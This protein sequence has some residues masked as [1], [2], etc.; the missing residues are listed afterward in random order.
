MTIKHGVDHVT[1]FG[2]TLHIKA[3]NFHKKFGSIFM[4]PADFNL[5]ANLTDFNQNIPNTVFNTPAQPNGCTGMTQADVA[6]DLDH[7][8]YSPYFT[9]QKTCE[10]EDHDTTQPCY[11]DNSLNSTTVYGVQ[12]LGETDDQ[13]ALIH[14]KQWYSVKP[15]GGD[16]FLG[17]V[18]AMSTGRSSVSFAADWYESFESPVDGVV[19]SAGGLSSGHN[20]KFCGLKTIND[21]QYLIA[22]P[23]I[24]PS[25]GDNGFCYFSKEIVNGLNGQAFTLGE[26]TNVAQ[27]RYSIMETLLVYLQRLLYIYQQ[28]ALG[29]ISSYYEFPNV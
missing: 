12:A 20:W 14:R 1:L 10:M 23:W 9:Y 11:M 26:A 24:G 6:T 27:V 19:P 4:L 25:W 22:K 21:V 2:I 28:G 7:I 13:Q 16:M 5:D 3:P 17:I 8:E 15:I 29:S 18:S